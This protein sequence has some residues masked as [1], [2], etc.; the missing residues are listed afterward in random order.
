MN[1]KTPPRQVLNQQGGFTAT[2]ERILVSL[3]HERQ[4]VAQLAMYLNISPNAVRAQLQRLGRDGLVRPYGS[5]RGVRR[6]HVEYEI[7]E[8]AR[9]RLPRAYEPLLQKLVVVLS[10]RLPNRV[11]RTLLLRSGRLLLKEHLGLV[12]GRTPR[13]R[14]E[15]AMHK[16]NGSGLAVLTADEGQKLVIRCCSCPIA[17]ITAN[18]PEFCA[19]FANVLGEILRID[20]RE[21]C[22]RGQ[23]PQCRF[24][25]WH[26]AR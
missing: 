7:T 9:K 8:E 21:K 10:D 3:C 18:H 26:A 1:G 19:L 17:S 15:A 23:M 4:T 12:R 20:V 16:I 5:R 11:S 22:K 25:V 6:P 13:Q 14:L 24:E 2:K